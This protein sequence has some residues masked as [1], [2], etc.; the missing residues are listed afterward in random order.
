MKFHYMLKKLQLHKEEYVLMQAI[1]LFSPGDGLLQADDTP[2]VFSCFPQGRF[3]PIAL[4]RTYCTARGEMLAG[5][6]WVSGGD[7]QP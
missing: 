4:L 7:L 2:S 1:S 3:Q 6:P 5:F